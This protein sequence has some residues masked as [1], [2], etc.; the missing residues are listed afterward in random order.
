MVRSRGPKQFAPTMVTSRLGINL[1]DRIV[2]EMRY[3]W[4]ETTHVDVGIDGTIELCRP[5]TREALNRIIQVQSK[6]TAGRFPGETEEGFE[7]PCEAR[8]VDHWVGGNMPVIV[9]VSRTG[10]N[11]DE[12][13]WI[14]VKRYFADPAA[15]RSGRIRFHKERDR[16]DARCAPALMELGAPASDSLYLAPAP[17]EETLLSNLLRVEGYAPTIYVADTA[18]RREGDL[19]AHFKERGEEPGSEWLLWEGRIYS[20]LDLDQPLFRSV[21]DPGTLDPI[22]T[23]HLAQSE[24]RDMTYLFI[25]LLRKALRQRLWP[26]RVRFDSRERHYH[27]M[28]GLG[29]APYSHRYRARQ[30]VTSRAVFER[31]P[32]R[33]DPKKT[34][35]YRHSAFS[36]RFLR[37][38]GVWYLEITP[39]YRFTSDGFRVHPF[40]ADY[41]KKMKGMEL[42][43]AIAGQVIMWAEVLRAPPD[44]M[45]PAYP[46]LTFGELQSFELGVGFDETTWQPAD[47]ADPAA[48]ADADG[49][50]D[51]E[52]LDL[53]GEASDAG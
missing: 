44:L 43:D 4:N 47:P 22:D 30:K 21:C 45:R 51:E 26:M 14:D 6:A 34:A 25:R 17:R 33:R 13:Y 32:D 8:D 48:R 7:W 31:Y 24:D 28:A 23:D 42:N 38:D 53:F 40:A 11:Q 35:Y 37:L 41:V 39:T 50:E 19:W 3:I 1:I 49:E 36:D 2:T 52:V 46:L 5:D 12:A 20:F 10:V 27:F 18:F 16:F 29:L 15:R 9:I